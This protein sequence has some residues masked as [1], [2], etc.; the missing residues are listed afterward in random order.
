M[1]S[2]E[3]KICP[4]CGGAGEISFFQ[5]ESRFFLTREECPA[6]YGVGYVMDNEEETREENR[7]KDS[8]EKL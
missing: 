4:T 6:C 5:G 1:S 3:K 7:R 2:Y 8:S